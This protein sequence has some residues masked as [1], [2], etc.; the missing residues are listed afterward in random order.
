MYCNDV[1]FTDQDTIFSIEILET[2]WIYNIWVDIGSVCIQAEYYGRVIRK[3]G[4]YSMFRAIH[5]FDF[6]QSN[7]SAYFHYFIEGKEYVT[8]PIYFDVENFY[9]A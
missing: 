6:P 4:R 2:G 7:V 3:C 8:K 9:D 1:T 5:I